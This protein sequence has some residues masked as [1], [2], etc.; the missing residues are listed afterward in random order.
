MAEWEYVPSLSVTGGT[1]RS[2]ALPTGEDDYTEPEYYD[3]LPPAREA[4]FR[5]EN[6]TKAEF[7]ELSETLPERG[8][9]VQVTDHSGTVWTGK[10]RSLSGQVVPGTERV[11]DVELTIIHN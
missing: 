6:M 2:E 3:L 10:F 4:R 8:Q 1:I 7:Y 9:A 5:S 11:S